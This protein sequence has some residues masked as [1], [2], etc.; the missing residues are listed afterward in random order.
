M[1][2]VEGAKVKKTYELSKRVFTSDNMFNRENKWE[3]ERESKNEESFM[4][5][6][7]GRKENGGM[8]NDRK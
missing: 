3:R 8:E 5:G 7:N 4:S 2:V 1:Q 6:K